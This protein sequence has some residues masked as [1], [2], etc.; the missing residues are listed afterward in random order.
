MKWKKRAAIASAAL[1]MLACALW[2]ID[3]V[4]QAPLVLAQGLSQA[5][6]EKLHAN[7][8]VVIRRTVVVEEKKPIAELAVVSRA[9]DVEQRMTS[10]QYFSEARLSMRATFNVKAG[11]DL[12]SQDFLLELDPD[13]KHARLVLTAPRVLSLEMTQYQVLEDKGG[14]WHK[15]SESQRELAFRQLQAQAKLEAIR[16]GILED[17]KAE[18]Q[19]WLASV[20][21]RFGLELEYAFKYAGDSSKVSWPQLSSPP[22]EGEPGN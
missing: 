6:G 12:R 1:L 13:G 9:T 3:K 17:C 2:V 4:R 10:E 21:S 14:W 7:P 18:I 15:F 20:P 8:R 22:A 19:K 11:F 5:V 16:A